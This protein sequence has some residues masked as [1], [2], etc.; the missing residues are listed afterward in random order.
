VRRETSDVQGI[1]RLANLGDA[2]ILA[3]QVDEGGAHHLRS[4]K[5]SAL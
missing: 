3:L 4:F 5:T 1:L 2:F